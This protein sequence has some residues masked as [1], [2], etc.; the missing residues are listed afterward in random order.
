MLIHIVNNTNCYDHQ[1]FDKD[2]KGVSVKELR[3]A[4]KSIGKL[5]VLPLSIL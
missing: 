1:V 2:R 4:M 5:N 3:H